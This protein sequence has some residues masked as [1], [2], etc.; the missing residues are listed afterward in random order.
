M[1]ELLSVMFATIG[2]MVRLRFLQKFFSLR[3]VNLLNLLIIQEIFLDTLMPVYLE[4]RGVERIM[5]LG[6]SDVV[7][8]SLL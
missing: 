7:N 3:I 2:M 4:S 5:I 1:L 6:S 8:N